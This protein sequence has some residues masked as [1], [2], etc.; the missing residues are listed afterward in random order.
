[1][2]HGSRYLG[3]LYNDLITN[4]PQTILMDIP[5][6]LGRGRISQTKIKHG[7]ILSDWQMCYQ[8]DMNVQGPVSKEYIQIIFCLNDGISWGM[9]DENKSIT[10]QKRESCIYAGHGGTEYICYTKDSNFTFKSIKIPITYFSQLLT[11]YFDGQEAAAYEKKLLNGISKVPVTP[12]MEQILAETSQFTQYRGG[13][14]YLYL[15]GKLLELL[16]IYLGEV[17]ELDILMG[18]NISMSRTERTAIMEAK[19]IIDSQLAFAPSCEELSRLVHL[20]VTKLTRGFSSF[21]GMPIHQYVIEQRLVQAAQLLLEG[22]WNV[23]EVAA[24]VGYGK[25]SNFAAAFK[26]KY[27]V[28][29]KNYRESRFDN[30]KNKP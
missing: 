23:S 13:L 7:I 11:D 4:S 26:K 2:T 20:S 3:K 19:R 22:D 28:A 27:G 18:K 15:D 5:S 16:S 17:L 1:M 10:I 9:M 6:D 14:G 29:P 21:Y 30:P 25:P 12:A 24:I 8:A